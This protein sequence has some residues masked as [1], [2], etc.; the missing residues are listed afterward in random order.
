MPRPSK[1]DAAVARRVAERRAR[2]RWVKFVEWMQE[3]QAARWVFRG[4]PKCATALRPAIG[5]NAASWDS[6]REFL[7][8]D[9]FDHRSRLYQ[10][11]NSKLQFIEVMAW[12]QHHGLPTRLLDWTTNPLA[13]AFFAV[14]TS[15]KDTIV[16]AVDV[17]EV[18]FFAES[19]VQLSTAIRA[20]GETK[21]I[22]TA[23]LSPR[24]AAQRGLFSLHHQPNINW[25]PPGRDRVSDCFVIEAGSRPYFLQRLNQLGFDAATIMTDLDGLCASLRW[26][27]QS[28]LPT[29]STIGRRVAIR[30]SSRSMR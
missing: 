22:E 15:R 3:R 5:R 29:A 17:A 10:P 19:D 26:W 4:E 6:G 9:L 20:L 24:I 2:E 23:P 12:S 13:A 27:Y 14:Q 25:K 8:Y 28:G 18:G 21:F 11:G 16:H 30:S 1:A 7:L